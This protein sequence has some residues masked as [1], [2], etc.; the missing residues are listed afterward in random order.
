MYMY[1]C[2]MSLKMIL[3]SLASWTHASHFLHR[4]LKVWNVSAAKLLTSLRGHDDDIA[5][6]LNYRRTLL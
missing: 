3:F 4:S 6:S 5:V 2:S 1:I